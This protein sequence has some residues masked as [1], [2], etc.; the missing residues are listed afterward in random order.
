[1]AEDVTAQG[2][3]GPEDEAVAWYA[4][5]RSGRLTADESESLRQWLMAD[6]RHQ[7]AYDDVRG[8]WEALDEVRMDPEIL[9][10]REDAVR[11]VRRHKGFVVGAGAAASALV[12]VVVAALFVVGPLRPSEPPRVYATKT[13]EQ[14][15]LTLAD[16]SKVLL[17]TDS[18]MK[19]WSRLHGERRVDLLNG[20]AFFEVAKNP[21]RPFVVHVGHGSVTALGTAFDVRLNPKGMRVVL[22]EGKVR[23]APVVAAS[24]AKPMAMVAGQQIVNDG[25]VMRLSPANLEVETSW[26]A[27]AL[28][29][30]EQPLSEVVAEVNRYTERKIEIVDPS[31]ADRKVSAVLKISD[32]A[33]FLEA[34]RSMRIARV[35]SEGPTSIRITGWGR[36]LSAQASPPANRR[37]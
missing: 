33:T 5:S 32:T 21:E 35:A 11:G 25:S 24:G 31:I 13:G 9:R 3:A 26:R 30:Q 27:G 17:D 2:A 34:I 20:R 15:S 10:V 4:R 16:G 19:V 12:A 8:A 6:L 23:V 37:N 14:A 29:F 28:V 18:R 22:V 1:M 7:D 36:G